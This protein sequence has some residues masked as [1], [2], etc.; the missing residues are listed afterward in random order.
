MPTEEVTPTPTPDVGPDLF[1]LRTY[2]RV[3]GSTA[4][5]PL[6]I[7]FTE[8]FTGANVTPELMPISKTH[9]AYLNLIAG[10]VDLILVTSPSEDELAAA[11]A[12][13]VQL[14]VIPV[15]REGFVF[16]TN[17]GNPVTSLT[18]DQLRDIYAGRITNWAEVGGPS[19]PITAYQRPENSG[20]Q[21]GMLDLV[22]H[23]T[24]MM[25][26]PQNVVIAG[27]QETVDVIA[28]YENSSGALGYS[29]YYFVTA[30]YGDLAAGNAQDGVRL[31]SVDGVAPT[32]ETI[33]SGAYPLTS[34][35]YIV[36]N[37]ASPAGSPAR[38][39]AEAMLST[40]GQ[41]V[42]QRAGYVPIVELPPETSTYPPPP[43]GP[44]SL[45]SPDE[46]I[47]LHPITICQREE[48]A[49]GTSV[50]RLT[51]DGLADQQV[52]DAINARF[53]EAQD[54]FARVRHSVPVWSTFTNAYAAAAPDPAGCTRVHTFGNVISLQSHGRGAN[55]VVN[56]RLD[57]GAEIA[58]RDLFVDG[59]N[60]E[61]IVAD[62]YQSAILMEPMEPDARIIDLIG[63][64]QRDPDPDFA[65]ITSDTIWV[66]V[67]DRQFSFELSD[68][69][70]SVAIVKRFTT[71]D[72]DRLYTDTQHT[73]TC[74]AFVVPEGPAAIC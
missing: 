49:H 20:S 57:T 17:A 26:A 44:Y 11:R 45:A 40:Y 70:Q 10:D 51:V 64:L 8:A 59:A 43:P 33:R 35:Y 2:P 5:H 69:W 31:L 67:G 18:V 14:E 39:L 50:L 9:Q 34:A 66:R 55:A 52:E 23:G 48:P 32:P 61:G 22:M 15:V 12:A 16:I 47:R 1:T 13:R 74:P 65:I 72:D 27:M 29:Y 38:V 68:Y 19:S 62:A 58:F 7:A 60:I 24:P 28:T 6:S 53:R 42:A 41:R 25:E 46:A 3:D 21:T 54:E 37:K 30:M 36:I 4:T 71:P 73:I 63:D 56:V